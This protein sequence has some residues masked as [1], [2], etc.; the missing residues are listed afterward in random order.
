MNQYTSTHLWFC[1]NDVMLLGMVVF[2]LFDQSIP[3]TFAKE[4]M[5]NART[6]F[7]IHDPKGKPWEVVYVP[8]NGSKLFSSG[9]RFLANGYGLAVGDLCTFRL[10]RPREMVLEVLHASS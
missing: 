1:T 4:H 9:W 10:V 3:V 7:V 8:S 2:I 5:P 6:K